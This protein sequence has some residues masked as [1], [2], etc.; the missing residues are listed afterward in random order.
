MNRDG[1]YNREMKNN[2]KW[3]G[4]VGSSG[5]SGEVVVGLDRWRWDR[6]VRRYGRGGEN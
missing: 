5:V 2:P 3:K 1:N 4:E 6:I